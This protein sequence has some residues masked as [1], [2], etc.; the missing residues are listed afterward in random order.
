MLR[1]KAFVALDAIAL[2]ESCLASRYGLH[3]GIV[4]W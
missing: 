3:G 2:L 1:G 4:I